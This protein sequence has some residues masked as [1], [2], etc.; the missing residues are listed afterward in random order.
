[1]KRFE[2]QYHYSVGQ[3]IKLNEAHVTIDAM[4]EDEAET[5]VLEYAR[6]KHGATNVKRGSIRE[7]PNIN[8]FKL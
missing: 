5:A 3:S 6:S 7:I 1:M 8:P 4:N 2:V